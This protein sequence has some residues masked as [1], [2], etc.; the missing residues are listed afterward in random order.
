MRA[1]SSPSRRSNW[2]G[3]SDRAAGRPLEGR[4]IGLH[5]SLVVPPIAPPIIARMAVTT[6]EVCGTVLASRAA[7]AYESDHAPTERPS[8]SVV[9]DGARLAAGSGG[10]GA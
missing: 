9:C 8:A 10:A 4:Y 7:E 6:N 1:A 2:R 5:G 3:R